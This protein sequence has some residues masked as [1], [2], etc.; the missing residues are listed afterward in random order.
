MTKAE[1]LEAAWILYNKY[2]DKRSSIIS[3]LEDYNISVGEFNTYDSSM[4]DYSI[5]ETDEVSPE[6]LEGIPGFSQTS[7]MSDA[8]ILRIFEARDKLGERLESIGSPPTDAEWYKAGATSEEN[9]AR[10]LPFYQ[11]KRSEEEEL[12]EFPGNNIIGRTL[13]GL[14]MTPL[15]AV[16]QLAGGWQDMFTDFTE[17]QHET[18]DFPWI[19]PAEMYKTGLTPEQWGI[20]GGGTEWRKDIRAPGGSTRPT[21][22]SPALLELEKE[23][24]KLY[25]QKR[26]YEESMREG[27]W[28]D[29]YSVEED[30]QSLNQVIIENKL[31]DPRLI[32][33]ER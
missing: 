2:P 1:A 18:K 4:T 10:L 6:V 15:G 5:V 32:N 25:G 16:T 17:E 27:G 11:Q 14:I 3:K 26:L 21:G 20:E 7:A 9:V 24:D 12:F 33:Q 13:S 19:V 28:R 29:V 30:I 23:L 31:L 8:E 22:Y